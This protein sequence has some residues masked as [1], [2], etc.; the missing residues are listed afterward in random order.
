M[1]LLDFKAGQYIQ[2]YQ[3]KSFSP[4]KINLEW[5]WRDPKINTLLAE[6]NKKLGELNAFSLYVP[7]IVFFIAMHIIKEATTSSKIEGTRTG[8]DEAL[9]SAE[10]IAPEKRDDWQEVQNYIKALNYS[11]EKLKELPLSTRLLKD[12]HKIL[13]EGV[14]GESKMPGE[15]RTSQ[16]WIGGASLKDAVFIPP[17][18]SEVSDLMGDL[19]N[20]IHNDKI[21]VP[22]LIR[23]A[24]AHYQFETIHPFL[25]GNGRLGRLMITLYL[26]STGL[27]DKP[28]L[29]VSDFFERR[30][31]LY[32][33]NLTFVRTSNNL[34]QWIKFFLVAVIET[35]DKGIYTFREILK[36]K[37][38]I[39]GVKLLS[40]G[41]RINNAKKLM[42]FLYRKPIINVKDVENVLGVTTKPA[43]AIIQEFEKLEIL[44]ELTGY[45][46]N[47]LFL[48]EKY[49]KL[50]TDNV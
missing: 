12:S 44:K 43:N 18:H 36:L 28:T 15:Y 33:D 1:N 30:K 22:H 47:R 16:N 3:Y 37:E 11:I 35:S 48:F 49:Y 7:D 40:L 23:I 20:F 45:K 14:R 50:F 6:A 17:Q 29:Y 24:I 27:L 32:Y 8:I 13:L 25:D 21:D 10:E 4:S 46:R 26:V 41:K 19:E 42:N 39:E 2:Q 31:S 38:N 34:I 5:T 9:L